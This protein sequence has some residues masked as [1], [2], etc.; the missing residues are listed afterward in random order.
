MDRIQKILSAGGVCSR[1]EAER[2]I[3]A[4]R[5]KVNGKVAELGQK[6]YATD[7]FLL[8]DKPLEI[9]TKKHYYILNKPKGY[10]C[11]NV[12]R[13][14][15]RV[16]DLINNDT[17]LFTV[18]RLDVNTTGLIIVTNDGEFSRMIESPSS[19]VTKTYI[20]KVDKMISKTMLQQLIDG[21]EILDG[22]MTKPLQYAEVMR[23]NKHTKE[24]SVK[25][26]LTEG[27]KNQVK[28]MFKAIGAEVINLTRVKIGNIKLLDAELGQYRKL[29][30]AE[31]EDL[32]RLSKGE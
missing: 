4:G 1:R 14:N 7:K 12:D 28:E 8:D 11:S 2:W 9:K 19:N 17:Y 24:S 5:L 27:K 18:G 13:E 23:K 10:I 25:L 32:T 30:K 31:I 3:V 22:Y 15:R 26:V 29:S 21:V 6:A 16:V 20:A